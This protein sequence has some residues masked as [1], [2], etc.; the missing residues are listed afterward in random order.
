MAQRR[1]ETPSMSVR[2]GRSVIDGEVLCGG[3][4]RGRVRAS[5]ST[6]GRC[7][8]RLLERHALLRVSD[9]SRL[10]GFGSSSCRSRRA[11][12]S[13]RMR[14]TACAPRQGCW[15]TR[16]APRRILRSEPPVWRPRASDDGSVGVFARTP[17]HGVGA[18][19]F[20]DRSAPRS[21]GRTPALPPGRSASAHSVAG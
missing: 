8:P 16:T 14:D 7:A 5:R 11:L 1:A 10:R 17:P 18:R 4:S 12:P 20:L 2:R 9:A 21:Q 15:E 6:S 19:V 3:S 13:S